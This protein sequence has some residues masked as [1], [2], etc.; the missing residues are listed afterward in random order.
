MPGSRASPPSPVPGLPTDDATAAENDSTS[1]SPTSTRSK[2]RLTAF[3]AATITLLDTTTT[4]SNT[5]LHTLLVLLLRYGCDLHATSR[6]PAVCLPYFRVP[7]FLFLPGTH[8][9]LHAYRLRVWR[10][11]LPLPCFLHAYLT[12]HC[13]SIYMSGTI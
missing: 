3:P 8:Y 5:I 6:R 10:T 4:S 7:P 11:L 2:N 12:N 1:S 13:L 9:R